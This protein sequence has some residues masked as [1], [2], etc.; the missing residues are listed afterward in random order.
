MHKAR[1]IVPSTK[2]RGKWLDVLP[3][4]ALGTCLSNAAFRVGAN[5]CIPHPCRSVQPSTKGALQSLSCRF[6]RHA[7]L[8]DIVKRALDVAGVHPL[9]DPVGLDRGCGKRPA[10]MTTFP[11]SRGRLLAREVA[12][13][14]TYA[15]SYVN[16]LAMTAGSTAMK[17]EQIMQNIEFEGLGFKTS[18]GW[19]ETA[20]KAHTPRTKT[21]L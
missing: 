7:A 8:N 15:V 12:V 17:A 9:L 13:L 20:W 14:G 6:Q 5:I 4:P 21:K 16:N 10:K 11:F 18:G 19:S 2:P 1:I 3:V